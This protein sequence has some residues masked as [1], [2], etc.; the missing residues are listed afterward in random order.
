MFNKNTDINAD[1]FRNI[2][3]LIKPVNVFDDLLSKQNLELG[4]KIALAAEAR[5]K[6]D[7][8]PGQISRSKGYVCGTCF[9]VI[10]YCGPNK[11]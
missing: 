1:L 7:L 3:S 4:T 2:V 8:P 10:R 6:S 9:C 11:I 5:V